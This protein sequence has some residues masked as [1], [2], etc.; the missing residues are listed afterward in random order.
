LILDNIEHLLEAADDVAQLLEACPRLRVLATSRAPL[1]LTDE[2]LLTL[3]PLDARAAETLF[4]ER[5]HAARPDFRATAS[6]RAA[7]ANIC[8]RLDGIPLAIELAAARIKVL[9]AEQVAERLAD[10]FRLLSCDDSDRPPRHRALRA[11]LDSSFFAL[12][13]PEKALL[14]HM[15]IFVAGATIEAV[16]RVCQGGPEVLDSLARLVDHSL[17]IVVEQDG[18]TRYRLL[19]PVRQYAL[20]RLRESGEE[21][22]VRAHHAD[23]CLELAE[24]AEPELL[25]TEQRVW[26]ERLQRE[27]PN[28]RQAVGWYL[29][30]A[31]AEHAQ[32]L[33]GALWKFCEVRGHAGE[34]ERWLTGALVLERAY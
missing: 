12:C 23:W 22:E 10:Y 5:A 15:A 6:N 30:R 26:M 31:D 4:V 14:R 7:M 8:A 18:A 2:H 3:A 33:A 17:V 21:A 20:E 1:N 9:S 29:D 28:L 11:A 32:R 24:Q 25:G 19:E 34:G 27:L 16:E 13:E